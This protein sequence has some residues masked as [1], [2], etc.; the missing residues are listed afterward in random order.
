MKEYITHNLITHHADVLILGAG[1]AGLRAAIAAEQAGARV[2]VVSKVPPTRSH[3]VAAQGGINAALGNITPDDWRW[4]VYDT[5]R[6]SDWLGDQDAI[7]FMCKNA[8]DAIRE[9]DAMGVNFTRDAGGNIYQRPYGGM[10]THFGKGDPAYRACAAADQTGDA[11]MRGLYKVACAQPI[12]FF[13]EFIA[14]DLLF[15]RE[16][17]A[18]GVLAWELATGKLHVFLAPHVILATGGFGQVYGATTASSTC[19]G[20]GN[21]M[22]LRAGLPLQDMEFVQFHPTGL[23]G[24]GILI[25]EAMRAE[26]GYLLNAQGERF[27]QR[28]APH[29]MELASRDVVTRAIIS[30][31]QAGRGAGVLGDHVL[32]D[33]SHLAADVIAQKLP[34][35]ASIALRF[36]G[37][38]IA[39][40][41][42][43]VYPTAHYTMGG[44]PT[45][46]DCQVVR[47]D[48]S[49]VEGLYAIGEAACN[50]VHGS[51]RLGCNSLLDL[52][53][54]GKHAGQLSAVGKR[55]HYT[56]ADVD[57]AV[58]ERSITSFN[59][60]LHAKGS[61]SP[62]TMR[63]QLGQVMLGHCGILRDATG[64]AQGA[65][66]LQVLMQSYQQDV[67]VHQA[68]AMWNNAL[69]AAIEL[70]NLL[71]QARVMLHSATIRTE[72]RGAHSRTD[73]PQRDDIDWL[74]H[75]LVVQGRQGQL[76]Y[77]KRAVRMQTGESGFDSVTP[78]SRHY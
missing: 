38:D 47:T 31:I 25:S 3:T 29:Y 13:E 2:M 51:N 45:N 34:A 57:A 32:L 30:E 42:V 71:L 9:L 35:N 67:C 49:I 8:P 10:S 54:F 72:S 6:G 56:L 61:T 74:H 21:A 37:V 19:T 60:L 53:V 36:A 62:T 28:Y 65:D 23:Y 75:S 46:K 5:V 15:T 39:S 52:I 66:A 50:S 59:A 18:C 58:L 55:T 69:V 73:Y 44:I 63:V 17:S 12:A 7:T 11:I 68:G 77:C 33:V 1:G 64:L 16:S 70:E 26:G 78:E 24:V 14:L 43:P 22:V 40:D 20:D 76:H 27:M 4:H 41:P 48:E